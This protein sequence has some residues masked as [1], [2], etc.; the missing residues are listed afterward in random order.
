MYCI[1]C[2]GIGRRNT[3]MYIPFYIHD[4]EWHMG[5]IG[6]VFKLR[7]SVWPSDESVSWYLYSH[8]TS[9]YDCEMYRTCAYMFLVL[10]LHNTVSS[11]P[12]KYTWQ[13]IALYLLH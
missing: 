2:G 5:S 4:D 10:L 7:A 13:R 8:V 12:H 9:P 6:S 1:Q 3:R 11:E